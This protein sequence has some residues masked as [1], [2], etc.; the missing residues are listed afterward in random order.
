[1]IPA[2]QARKCQQVGTCLLAVCLMLLQPAIAATK[3]KLR[4]YLTAR[5]DDHTL[6][7][8]DDKLEMTVASRII[9]Q[10]ASGEHAMTVAELGPGM[11]IEAEGQWLERHRFFAEKIT[12]DLK[13]A[14]KQVHGTAYL[15]EEPGEA[16]KISGGE[17]A[18]LKAD[19]YWMDLTAQTRRE[20]DAVKVATSSAAGTSIGTKEQ[21]LAGYQVRYSGVRRNDGRIGAER[22]E[23][24]APAPVDAYKMPHGVE[25][26][27]GKDLQN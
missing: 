6:A 8:L 16:S 27:R 2:V 23:L 21:A 22:I 17:A 12:V 3:M 1:M 4:G 5:V 13:D 25:V 15:Q 7:L 10:D 20:W 18:A 9:G 19:G 14:E 26:V 11:L 24:G